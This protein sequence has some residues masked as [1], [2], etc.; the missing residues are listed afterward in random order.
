MKLAPLDATTLPV[1]AEWLGREDVYRW[2]DFGLGVQRITLPALKLMAQRD[3]HC[4]RV[5]TAEEEDAP[6]IGI[7]GMSNISK[8]FRTATIWAVLGERSHGGRGHTYRATARLLT[9]AF[10]D[11]GLASVNAWAV[12]SNVASQR[13]L[14]RLGFRVVGRQRQCHCMDGRLLDR[15]LYDLLPSEHRDIDDDHTK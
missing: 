9:Y 11:M 13:I 3:I 5:H 4:L 12:E 15:I 7:I 2:L 10:R 6:P 14:R 1:V 8:A